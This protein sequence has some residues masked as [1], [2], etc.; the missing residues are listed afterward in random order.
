M[1]LYSAGLIF[2]GGGMR[3]AYTTGVIDAFLDNDLEFSRC[4]GVSSVPAMLLRSS[5]NSA[6]GLIG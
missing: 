5:P 6:D 1:S 2:E 4:Y 3:G